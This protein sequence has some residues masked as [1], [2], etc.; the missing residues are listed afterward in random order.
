MSDKP[1]ALRSKGAHD[2]DADRKSPER[3]RGEGYDVGYGKPP[4]QTRFVKGR[5]GNPRGRPRKVKPQPIKLSDA[6]SDTFLEREAYRVVTL[7]ENGQAI[8]LPVMQAVLRS[9]AMDA[10]KGKRLSQ[11]YLLEHVARA[12]ELHLQEKLQ[13]YLRLDTLKR[14]GER[15]LADRQRKGL[16]APDLLPHPDDIVLNPRTGQAYINGPA[17]PEDVAFY[18]HSVRLRDY[19]LLRAAHAR[20]GH[21]R[22]STEGNDNDRCAYMILAHLLDHALPLRFRWGEHDALRLIL[23]YQSL[24]RRELELR[25]AAEHRQLET[26]K[27]RYEMLAP[28]MESE[29]ERLFRKGF[30]AEHS[31][32]QQ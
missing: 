3:S 28:A 11:K 10:I 29:V 32:L 4:K 23:E 19:C 14:D 17:M 12:E 26:T 1:K 30:A 8:E 20:K 24:S 21:G 15:L 25:I 6:P 7:R 9:M 13:T 22:R 31:T 2:E 16:P 18:D 5:S 27:P